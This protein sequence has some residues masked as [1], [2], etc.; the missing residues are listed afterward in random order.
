MMFEAARQWRKL[1][2]RRQW[3]IV[4]AAIP[5]AALLLAIAYFS[6]DGSG[7]STDGQ[8]NSGPVASI[9]VGSTV[10]LNLP[11]PD[12]F[13]PITPEEALEENAKREFSEQARHARR[14][15][16]AQGGRRQPRPRARMPDPGRLL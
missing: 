2:R 7:S 15:I 4:G 13:R 5:F 1:H 10:R 8:P 14:A 3:L 11:P 12:L 6:Y 9:N 16:H